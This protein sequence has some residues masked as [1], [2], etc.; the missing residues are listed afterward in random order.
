A[1]VAE[2]RYLRLESVEFHYVCRLYRTHV[3]TRAALIYSED[4][5]KP[6]EGGDVYI[7]ARRRKFA[8]LRCAACIV[9]RSE[10]ASGEEQCIRLLTCLCVGP[11]E[12]P[13]I[14]PKFN[15]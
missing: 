6:P 8:D 1:G 3:R 10:V 15:W 11:K 9:D 2:I 12:C 4:G 13:H 14:E 7:K 5:W